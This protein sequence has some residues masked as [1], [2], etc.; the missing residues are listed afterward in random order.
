[1][2]ASIGHVG[3]AKIPVAT[4][5]GL[6]GI[7]VDI[8][9]I[10]PEYLFYILSNRTEEIQN[11]AVGTTIKEVRPSKFKRLFKLPLPPLKVQRQIILN[12]KKE[13]KKIE[14]NKKEIEKS[15]EIILKKINSL[16]KI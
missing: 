10:I 15:Q 5:Q 2:G 14:K 8:K 6:A 9:K 11:L 4:K 13:E 16:W 1:M 3:I 12:L 7:I